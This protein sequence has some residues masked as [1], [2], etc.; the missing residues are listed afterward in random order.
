M[1]VQQVDIDSDALQLQPDANKQN[2]DTNMSEQRIG[3]N[4]RK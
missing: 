2:N 3:T 4:G 1:P